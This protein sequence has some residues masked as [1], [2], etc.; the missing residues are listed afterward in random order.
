MG[1]A[2]SCRSSHH[3]P[4]RHISTVG[5]GTAARVYL[6]RHKGTRITPLRGRAE[7]PTEGIEGWHSNGSVGWLAEAYRFG[8]A[9][10]RCS[11]R[12]LPKHSVTAQCGTA[13]RDALEYVDAIQQRTGQRVYTAARCA[14]SSVRCCGQSQQCSHAQLHVFG[15]A[16]PCTTGAVCRSVRRSGRHHLRFDEI[17]FGL[18]LRTLEVPSQVPTRRADAPSSK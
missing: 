14:D 7:L 16:P 15:R 5:T 10:R 4:H 9:L 13:D 11:L 12:R 6:V 17:A 18:C 2:K 1:A 8:A 3:G